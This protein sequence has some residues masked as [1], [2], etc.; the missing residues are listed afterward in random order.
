MK[1]I[2]DKFPQHVILSYMD[3]ITILGNSNQLT[4]IVKEFEKAFKGVGLSIN[5]QKSKRIVG[6]YY[7][8]IQQSDY[9]NTSTLTQGIEILGAYIGD[10]R[11]QIH[12]VN[13]K[14][15]EYSDILQWIKTLPSRIG[16][17]LLKT[18]V[19]ARPIYLARTMPPWVTKD[20]FANFDK[21]IDETLLTLTGTGRTE[22]PEISKLLRGQQMKEGGLGIAI[23]QDIADGAYTASFLEAMH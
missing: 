4:D 8:D 19:N 5:K 9:Q 20:A 15:A 16:Y 23:I 7:L 17:P 18:C 2:S 3:D 1:K 14:V 22:L 21:S 12:Y 11:N 6:D 10:I 13:K